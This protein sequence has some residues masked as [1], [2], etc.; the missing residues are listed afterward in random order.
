MPGFGL[1][2]GPVNDG[3]DPG[4][5][6]LREVAAK[7]AASTLGL[8]DAEQL[9]TS[10][11]ALRKCSARRLLAAASTLSEASR[12]GDAATLCLQ[13]R[14]FNVDQDIVQKRVTLAEAD[15]LFEVAAV[16]AGLQLRMA[17]RLRDAWTT[18]LQAIAEPS[19]QRGSKKCAMDALAAVSLKLATRCD[20]TKQ[21]EVLQAAV[22]A[23]MVQQGTL[24]PDRRDELQ[25]CFALALHAAKREDEAQKLLKRL[26]TAAASSKRRSQAQWALLVQ[27][28]DV[29]GEA[30]EGTL[31]LRAVWASTVPAITPGSRGLAGVGSAAG[32][33]LGSRGST[34]GLPGL[35]FGGGAAPLLLAAAALMLPLG[36]LA[37]LWF[38]QTSGGG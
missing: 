34:G 12:H 15:R 16:Q 18:L 9:L 30:N 26:T 22:D 25:I 21:V 4:G 29:S 5:D 8:A 7:A 23:E 36:V 2:D 19:L 37:L 10:D 38:R 14:D 28:A 17:G 32:R 24:A 35:R 1:A 13:A 31:E 27:D 3:D 6:W 33:Q 20:P 11:Q